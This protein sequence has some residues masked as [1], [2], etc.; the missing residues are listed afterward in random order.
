MYGGHFSRYIIEYHKLNHVMR[1]ANNEQ[2]NARA[3][4][5][6]DPEPIL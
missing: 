1:G 3:E 2:P 6:I 4:P 5:G